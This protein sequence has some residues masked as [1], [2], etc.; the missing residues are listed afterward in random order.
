MI[1][2]VMVGRVGGWTREGI[3][4]RRVNFYEGLVK[5]LILLSVAKYGYPVS[6]FIF[7]YLKLLNLK[8]K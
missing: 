4:R 8:I 7:L 3:C 1:R 5:L 2:T 6:K